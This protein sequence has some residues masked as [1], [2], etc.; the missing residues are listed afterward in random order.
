MD[1]KIILKFLPWVASAVLSGL[2]FLAYGTINNQAAEIKAGTE[3]TAFQSAVITAQAQAM[4]IRDS[5][6]K[7]QSA[8]I[9]QLAAT[10]EI[11]RA[12]Y[13]AGIAK[14]TKIAGDH[15]AAA[16]TLLS[17]SAPEGELAQCRAARDLLEAELVP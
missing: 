4:D 11:E 12:T 17:L 8:S 2:L 13:K 5:I 3:V 1:L 16:A 9:D 14:A 7:T 15:R 10:S 6:I